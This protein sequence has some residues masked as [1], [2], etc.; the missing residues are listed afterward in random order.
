MRADRFDILRDLLESAMKLDHV[1]IAGSSLDRLRDAFA[2]IGLA[3]EY[4][5]A[6]ANGVTHMALLG[7]DDGSYIE[8]ASTVKPGWRSVMILQANSTIF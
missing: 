7:F 5:G 8:L 6:H 4:G 2:R 3:T 1:T